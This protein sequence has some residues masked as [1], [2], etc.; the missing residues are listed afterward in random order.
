MR[1]TIYLFS[2]VS[3][4]LVFIIGCKRSEK[5][6]GVVDADFIKYQVNYLESM[7]GD[8]P[9]RMLPDIMEAY[10][11]KRF[12]KTSISGF[13]GQ[14]SLVQV[15]DLR[16][17]R[18]TTM[19]N[20]FGNKVFYTGEKGE[21]PAGI[22]AINDPIVNITEDT[23][24]ICGMI[25]RRA[26]VESDGS[27]FDLF[28]IEEINIKSP[29]ITTPYHFIDHVLSDFRVQLSILKMHLTMSDHEKTTVDSIV[30][31]IPEDYKEVSRKTM[32]TII[33]NLFT[34]D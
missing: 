27:T 6:S 32:E 24:T 12:I 25:S 18:V 10:Y 31:E 7:A 33:N 15:A 23:A 3:L 16:Q 14:F 26:T 8:I 9:T 11:T 19:L 1:K 4:S 28:F 21:L 13:F 20:F 2:L 5:P 30:F 34:K 22:A 29:N 17:N